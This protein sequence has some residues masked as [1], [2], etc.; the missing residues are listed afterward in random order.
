MQRRTIDAWVEHFPIYMSNMGTR[1]ESR[2]D[3]LTV[4]DS[5]PRERYIL[6][7][8]CK[9]MMGWQTKY[10]EDDINFLVVNEK[11]GPF[12]SHGCVRN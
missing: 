2:R 12:K 5:K 7:A 8:C 9:S 4:I 11:R 10:R 6:P 1:S 3:K